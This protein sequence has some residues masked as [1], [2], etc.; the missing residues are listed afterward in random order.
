MKIVLNLI[1]FT[2]SLLVS[3]Q[4][5]YVLDEITMDPISGA[6]LYQELEDGKKKGIMSDIDGA[7]S[8]SEFENDTFI[9]ISHISYVNRILEFSNITGNIM[10][11]P[12]SNNLDEIVI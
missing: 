3:S 12:D 9:T 5:I 11:K 6:L 8:L 10:L 1:I 2:F 7:I 4:E